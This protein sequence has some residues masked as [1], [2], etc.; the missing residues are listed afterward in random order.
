MAVKSK[1]IDYGVLHASSDTWLLVREHVQPLHIP[2]DFDIS[3]EGKMV[4]VIGK[5][6]KPKGS[7]ETRLIVEKMVL[8]K[9]IAARAEKIHQTGQGGSAQDD[10][11]R[12]ERELLGV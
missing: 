7:S 5:M 1:V 2:F 9:D 3:M 4:S 11:V 6:G 8:H 10:W 12:A